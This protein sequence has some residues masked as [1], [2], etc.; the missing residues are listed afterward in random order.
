MQSRCKCDVLVAVSITRRCPYIH[1]SL[2]FQR[3][4][5]AWK[6][7]PHVSTVYQRG[8]RILNDLIKCGYFATL[9]ASAIAPC[10]RVRQY[11]SFRASVSYAASGL[12]TQ[13]IVIE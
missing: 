7:Q 8:S 5:S 12:S 9:A 3:S 13:L 2:S 10:K 11:L 6:F 4:Q 1:R